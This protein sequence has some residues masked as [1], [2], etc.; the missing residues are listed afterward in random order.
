MWL[1]RE[2]I[3]GREVGTSSLNPESSRSHMVIRFFVKTLNDVGPEVIATSGPVSAPQVSG[4][5]GSLTLVDLAG[6]ERETGND[7]V[8]RKGD[9]KAINVSLTHLN[10]MLLNMQSGQLKDADR[11]QCALNMVLHESLGEDCGTTMIF[12]YSP[13]SP[14][15][16]VCSLDLADGCPL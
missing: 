8:S 7:N 11:R 16:I 2:A 12:L 3:A 4:V 10:I 9:A 14:V 15:C 6:S 13:R 1:L 5:I